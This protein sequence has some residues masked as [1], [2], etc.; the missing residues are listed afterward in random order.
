MLQ[1]IF[2]SQTPPTMD[3]NNLLPAID[4][5]R[6]KPC[7]TDLR[8]AA[9][10]A[11]YPSIR[12]HA[13]Q[14]SAIDQSAFHQVA[15]MVYGWMPRI[16]RLDLRYVADAT[17]ALNVSAS[18]SLETHA[19]VSVADISACVRSV[20]G[21]SKM[22]H[23]VNDTIFPIWDSRIETLRSGSKPTNEHMGCVE[24]FASYVKE[25]HAIRIEPGFADFCDRFRAAYTDRLQ[26]MG[27]ATYEI[28]EVRVVE[29]AA[30]E[31]ASQM[32]PP[33]PR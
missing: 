14:F 8:A 26:A 18:A 11:T 12:M 28:S 31:L 15:A 2:P 1:T 3:L 27:I 21:T 25:V 4:C 19:D 17:T 5:I 7:T 10:L 20:V 22:L 6:E 24:N 30:F 32:L 23:F 9:Y 16:L 13:R 33:T 29:A